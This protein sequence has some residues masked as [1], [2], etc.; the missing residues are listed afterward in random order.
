MKGA[1]THLS[2][3]ESISETGMQVSSWDALMN[4]DRTDYFLLQLHGAKMS[5]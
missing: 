1:Y 4:M 5:S 3:H 2:K